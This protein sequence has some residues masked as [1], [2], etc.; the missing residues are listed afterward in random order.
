[1]RSCA[2]GSAGRGSSGVQIRGPW[3]NRDRRGEARLARVFLNRGREDR[4]QI[5]CRGFIYFDQFRLTILYS[6]LFIIS[7][8]S[9]ISLARLK[10]YALSITPPPPPSFL[11]IIQ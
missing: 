1:M 5:N 7:F 10:R 6:F 4:T 3:Q 2:D 9:F 11:D 8:N